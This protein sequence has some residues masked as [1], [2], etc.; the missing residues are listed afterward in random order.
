VAGSPRLHPSAQGRAP[1][2]TEQLLRQRV[3]STSPH[4]S[5]L[6]P[7]WQMQVGPSPFCRFTH[8]PRRW[9]RAGQS[10]RG[11][12]TSGLSEGLGSRVRNSCLLQV[13][14]TG[15]AGGAQGGHG[16]VGAQGLVQQSGARGLS[17]C[18]NHAVVSICCL[19]A[20]AV[21]S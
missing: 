19:L 9:Q 5:P 13:A 16:G 21:V 1:W 17:T 10:A 20:S 8:R 3:V 2:L 14:R 11:A 12:A 7:W 18:G 4:S 6:N 15:G